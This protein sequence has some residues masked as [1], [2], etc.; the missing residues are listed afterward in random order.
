MTKLPT[1]IYS[2]DPRDLERGQAAPTAELEFWW[3]DRLRT[4]DQAREHFLEFI[5][6]QGLA[7]MP[8]APVVVDLVDEFRLLRWVVRADVVEV[9]VE[10]R[11]PA[12]S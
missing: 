6:A 2:V 3:S 12:G 9:R 7:P 8:S 10:D 4:V 5:A 11:P 1:E